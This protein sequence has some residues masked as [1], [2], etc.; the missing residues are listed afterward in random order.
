MNYNFKHLEPLAFYT[1]TKNDIKKG[2]RHI[3]KRKPDGTLHYMEKYLLGNKE[4]DVTDAICEPTNCTW[5]LD[6][7]EL[8]LIEYLGIGIKKDYMG[9]L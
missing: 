9:H 6:R 1:L 2:W 4:I 7:L 5:L 3:F 8:E